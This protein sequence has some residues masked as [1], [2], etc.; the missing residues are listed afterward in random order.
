MNNESPKPLWVSTEAAAKA[1]HIGK[2]TLRELQKNE[3]EPGLHWTYL[4]GRPNSPIGWSLPAI[5]EWQS[6]STQRIVAEQKQAKQKRIERIES[7]D[8][9]DLVSPQEGEA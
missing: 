5:T 7:F 8:D 2:S 6:A 3:L 9:A 1:L 4:T